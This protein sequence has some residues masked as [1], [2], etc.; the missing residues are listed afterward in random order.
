MN[1]PPKKNRPSDGQQ[2]NEALYAQVDVWLKE[3]WDERFA[4]QVDQPDFDEKGWLTAM[5]SAGY[6][7]PTWPEKWYGL[8]LSSTQGR[9]VEKAFLAHKAPG[10]GRDRFHLGAISLFKLASEELKHELLYKLLTG[11]ICC[12]LYSEPNAGSD[13]AG[14]RTRAEQKGDEFVVNGQ[15]VWTSNAQEAEYGML[16]ARTDWKVPKH[17]GITFFIF[18]MKQA[19]VEVRPINQITGESEFNEVFITD[20]RVPRRFILGELNR[21][22]GSFQTAIAAERLIMGQGVTERI[23]RCARSRVPPLL[24]LARRHSRLTD[25]AI[26]QELAQILAYRHLNSLNMARAREEM[27]TRP[28]STLL[29]LGKLAMS[30]VQHS[31]ARMAGKILGPNVLLDGDNFPDSRNANFDAAKAYMNSIG[32]GTDQIQKNIIAEK[33]LGLP[34]DQEFDKDIPFS[35]VKSNQLS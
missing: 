24:D 11:P 1:S 15:K 33:I 23:G 31:E 12:L 22:W 21:G 13:L 26:R 34:K 20:A 16:L 5:V 9:I 4:K 25:P 17:Q 3:N 19:G 27:K 14:V 6:A 18:P 2:S 10:W 32:G 8:G 30:R 29:G 28:F 7:V 35:D